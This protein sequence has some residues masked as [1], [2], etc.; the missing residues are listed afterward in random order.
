MD[1][2]AWASAFTGTAV[3]DD[4]DRAVNT[5]TVELPIIGPLDRASREQLYGLALYLRSVYAEAT[6]GVLEEAA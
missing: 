6:V 3:R 5:V 2:Q 4:W 1:A